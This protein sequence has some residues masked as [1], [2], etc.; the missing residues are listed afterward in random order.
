MQNEQV[1]DIKYNLIIVGICET[2]MN[3]LSKDNFIIVRFKQ[4]NTRQ[5]KQQTKQTNKR[6]TRWLYATKW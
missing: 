3:I 6:K 2:D 4:Q 1:Y 5:K